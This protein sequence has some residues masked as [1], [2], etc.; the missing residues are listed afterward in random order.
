MKG[1]TW[2]IRTI[3]ST[4]G[5]EE[6]IKFPVNDLKPKKTREAHRQIDR[7]A[8]NTADAAR[9]F[10]RALNN[11]FLP[12][13]SFITLTLSPYGLRKVQERATKMA[14][15]LQA[16]GKEPP[17]DAD[18][19]LLAVEQ[20]SE[21]LNE[22]VRKACKKAGIEFIYA[23][24]ASD[25]KNKDAEP[26]SARPHIHA[27][28]NSAAADIFKEKWSKLGVIE[29]SKTLRGWTLDNDIKV[30][31][32]TALGNYIISQTRTINGEKR[33]S[34]ARGLKKSIVK[35]RI[36]KNPAAEIKPPAGAYLIERSPYMP[37]LSQYIRYI[38]EQ[39][40]TEEASL[41]SGEDRE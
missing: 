16:D 31:D 13:D 20:E 32:W 27:V 17:S 36:A 8:K 3:K 14:S 41:T 38:R 22:R 9:N 25:K 7:A 28:V 33:Y 6:K 18:L 39:P 34:L 12:Q 15:K 24:A 4:N 1:I 29:L 21:N 5:V 35:D 23:S 11:N 2:V 10:S 19:L 37:G 26:G 40:V 30:T